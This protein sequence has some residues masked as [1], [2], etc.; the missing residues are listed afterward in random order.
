MRTALTLYWLTAQGSISPKASTL[1]L[2][3][4]LSK[5][6]SK[7]PSVSLQC[8][9]AE[10]RSPLC[11]LARY[12]T[13]LDQTCSCISVRMTRCQAKSGDQP[14]IKAVQDQV[15]VCALLHTSACALSTHTH[16][17]HSEQCLADL[18]LV[19]MMM[20]HGV[21]GLKSQLRCVCGPVPSMFI[22]NFDAFAA[23]KMWPGCLL[24]SCK[25]LLSMALCSR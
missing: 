7:I 9:K 25:P 11:V 18:F 15:C 2:C 12:R 20:R 6:C 13:S 17:Q 23:E 1:G 4:E 22:L 5:P 3:L 16:H 10:F 24:G 14:L 21:L 19:W 8:S